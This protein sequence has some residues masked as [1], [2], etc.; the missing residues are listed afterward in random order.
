MGHELSL[1]ADR[2]AFF[3]AGIHPAVL[4]DSGAPGLFRT[5]WG[6]PRLG[7]LLCRRRPPRKLG[8]SRAEGLRIPEIVVN[9]QTLRGPQ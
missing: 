9:T 6:T 7:R 5:L 3:L 1:I 4:D 8:F 2:A